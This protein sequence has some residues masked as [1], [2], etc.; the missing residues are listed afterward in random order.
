[1]MRITG[2]ITGFVVAAFMMASPAL[3]AD[4]NVRL[5]DSHSH[6]L[7]GFYSYKP[8]SVY[9]DPKDSDFS[10]H[11][12]HWRT[13]TAHAATGRGEMRADGHRYRVTFRFYRPSRQHTA[14]WPIFTR[15]H[16]TRVGP[17]KRCGTWAFDYHTFRWLC[18]S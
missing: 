1:M 14:M 8:H 6:T 7:R 11:E 4:H 5:P 15:A 12:I 2:V 18:R 13:W 17:M 3:A 9:F 10:L 16:V